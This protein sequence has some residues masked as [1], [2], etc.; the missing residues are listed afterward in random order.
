MLAS[1]PQSLRDVLSEKDLLWL[2]GEQAFQTGRE[3]HAAQKYLFDGA[4][5]TKV[6]GIVTDIT[7]SY[8]VEIRLLG[9]GDIQYSCQCPAGRVEL[10]C[11]HCVACALAW[12]DETFDATDLWSDARAAI[13]EIDEAQSLRSQLRICLQQVERYELVEII[14]DWARR[15]PAHGHELL[16][17]QRLARFLHH[18]P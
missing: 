2:A 17:S 10:F 3:F 14:L 1:H 16:D 9:S 13:S 15:D 7:S 5:A 11:S 18:T 6:Q 8:S 4:N 12:L